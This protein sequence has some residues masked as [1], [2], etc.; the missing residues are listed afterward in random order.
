[1]KTFELVAKN[2]FGLGDGKIINKGD[3]KRVEVYTANVPRTAILDNPKTRK[4]IME[5][6]KGLD[7]KTF[8]EF[9]KSSN[10]EIRD[11]TN[12][13]LAEIAKGYKPLS[14]RDLNKPL[15]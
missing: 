13:S 4:E 7:Q 8:N 6:F 14:N 9:I 11:V 3:I 5:Q 10:F 1:M 2:T 15:W 12:V